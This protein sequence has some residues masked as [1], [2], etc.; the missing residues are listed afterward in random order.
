MRNTLSEL[1]LAAEHDPRLAAELEPG[2]RVVWAGRPLVR[3]LTGPSIGIVLFA[4]PW[5]AFAVFWIS[6]AAW[7]TWFGGGSGQPVASGPFVAFPLFGV[8]FVLIGLGMLSTPY[9]SMRAAR[10]TLYALTERRCIVW[11]G[12]FGGS[13]AVTSYRA[14]VLRSM[15]RTQRR[16][17]SGDLVFVKSITIRNRHSSTDTAAQPE[18]FLSVANVAELERLVRLTLLEG[19]PGAA[20]R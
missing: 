3:L 5:T 10:R 18:G 13:I 9:W 20:A 11:K 7:G 16:D 2:E 17:G 6:A 1:E 15:S 19:G 14:D 8:P 4:I 12:K